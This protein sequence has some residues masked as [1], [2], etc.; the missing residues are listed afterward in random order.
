MPGSIEAYY[1][2]I[3]RAGRDGLPSESV[4]LYS[5]ADIRLQRFFIDN[6]ENTSPEYRNVEYK[7]LQE[8]TSFG[9][10]QMCLQ[11]YIIQYFGEDM[12]D[13]G[14]CTNCIDTRELVDVTE[15]A[16]K[17]LSNVYRM[18]QTGHS[19]GKTSI[20]Q[21]LR[22]KLPEKM[23]WTKFDQLPTYGLMAGSPK[24]SLDALVDYLT[25]DGYLTVSGEYNSLSVSP[26]GAEVLKGQRQVMQRQPKPEEQV[27]RLQKAVGGALF[28]KL[29]E[30][31]LELARAQGRPPFMIFSDQTLMNMA[32]ALPQT[33]EEL[34][35]V[36]GIG[37]VKADQYGAD[38]LAVIAEYVAETE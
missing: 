14:R 38:F 34:L 29:R 15:S 35:Q 6:S 30:K 1:Q 16:Q 20:V 27:V 12:P 9:A 18:T 33:L 7:K 26:S 24:K 31:R 4:L 37:Q 11:R 17:I 28:E 36:S 13:C 25:A 3:G 19:A 8:M 22:G 5:P 32:A 10:T 21:V 2:E 23:A